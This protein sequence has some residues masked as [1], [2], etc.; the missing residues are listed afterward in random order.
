MSKK[1]VFIIMDGWGEG[2]KDKADAI[3]QADTKY[4]KRLYLSEN[5]AHAHLLTDGEHVGLPDGQMGNSEVG[6]LNIGAGRVVYQD[7]VKINRAIKNGSIE[8]NKVINN[9]FE[10][11]KKNNKKVHFL[12]LVS[13]GGVHSSTKHLMKLTDIAH[14][15]DLDD[16]FVHVLTDGRDTDPRS[17]AAYV[18][19][20]EDHIKNNGAK[21][22]SVCGRYYTMD[23]D[24]RWERIKRGYDLMVNSI[25]NTSHSA[26]DAIKNCYT[27]GK[28]D[29][30]VDPQVIVDENGKPLAKIEK[31]DVVFCF[32]FR[33]DRLREITTVLS[34]ENM[35]EFDMTTLPLYYVT[36]TKYDDKFKNIHLAYTKDDL[37]NT[38][39]EVMAQ[40]NKE[41]IR[42]AETEK[43]AHVTFFFSGGRESEFEGEKRILIPSPKVATYDL[44]P[45][46]SAPEVT[47]AIVEELKAN[48]PDLVVLNFANSDMV[49]H[50][51]V[52]SAIT[53]A[54][55]TVDRSVE[56]VAKTARDL[57]YSVIITADHGNSDNAVNADGSPN[58][59][60]SM[61]PVPIFLLDDNYRNIIDGKLADIAPTILKI[62]ELPIPNE[63][64]GNV[65]V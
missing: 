55:E 37:K 62:M 19:E 65:L 64:D 31:D 10:Y 26:V 17:G 4:I 35:P 34:Q 25:G 5:A 46:M 33:T 20:L 21:I 7:L 8:Q 15:Y 6:H 22:A 43:Y 41:Q 23:R 63:M 1:V 36:M 52:Y 2:K 40:Q 57:G 58:T 56:R 49:G 53:E 38:L 14:Q 9:A 45:Q 51:G 24:K 18:Q 60:H 3:Y 11:A 27:E 48:Q 32:N 13:D 30:F 16:V 50:T 12:G 42:I 39:G 29:E 54:V 59:A 61:N 47:D 28:T 44:Q